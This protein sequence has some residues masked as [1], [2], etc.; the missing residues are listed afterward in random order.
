VSNFSEDDRNRFL[1]G[2]LDL[3]KNCLHFTRKKASVINIFA[4]AFLE[5]LVIQFTVIY[6]FNGIGL[7]DIICVLA[8][9]QSRPTVLLNEVCGVNILNNTGLLLA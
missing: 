3:T 2:D 6:P 5:L 7:K 4:F 8:S 9:E 1:R